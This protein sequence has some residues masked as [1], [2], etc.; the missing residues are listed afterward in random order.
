MR[1]FTDH[2][3]TEAQ[4]SEMLGSA[5]GQYVKNQ[6]LER[7]IEETRQLRQRELAQQEHERLAR[8]YDFNRKTRFVGFVALTLI[9]LFVTLTGGVGSLIVSGTI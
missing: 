7:Q 5:Y 3:F 1:F 8:Q 6:Q 2:F 9:L 4:K